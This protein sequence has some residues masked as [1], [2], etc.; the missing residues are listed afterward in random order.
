MVDAHGVSPGQ[1][2][3]VFRST[4]GGLGAVT[5]LGE[6]IAVVVDTDATAARMIRLRGPVEIGDLVA[7]QR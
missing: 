4:L 6:A 3:T 5:E 2:L 7:L 1:R